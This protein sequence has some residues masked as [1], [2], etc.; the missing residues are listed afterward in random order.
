MEPPKW[1]RDFRRW[2]DD[3]DCLPL[4][5]CPHG[6]RK[7]TFELL[8]APMPSLRV[9]L[10]SIYI[11]TSQLPGLKL[12]WTPLTNLLPNPAPQPVPTH[13]YYNRGPRFMRRGP[14]RL[15]WFGL[16]GIATYWFIQ[17]REQKREM[18]MSQGA[19]TQRAGH[20]HAAWGWGRWGDHRRE[21]NEAQQKMEDHR[22]KVQEQFAD[23]GNIGG[24]KVRPLRSLRVGHLCTD[25]FSQLADMAESSLDSV[26]SSVVAL[27][28]VSSF[29][30]PFVGAILTDLVTEN[31]R[32]ASCIASCSSR[33]VKGRSS[34][35]VTAKTWS[36][37]STILN[38][39]LSCPG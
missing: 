37:T 23:F 1:T 15:I 5:P 30:L 2:P 33:G 21:M 36:L 13:I 11:T 28:A 6:L 7:G 12:D 31:S 24:D 9:I 8:C 34:P 17:S 32:T 20:C 4:S 10:F 26:M 3:D 19:D 14:S 27:K 22:R 18:L 39:L 25:S 38:T 16:G 35:R 29:Q